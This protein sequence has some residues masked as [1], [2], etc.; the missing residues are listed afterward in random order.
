MSMDRVMRVALPALLLAL[1]ACGGGGG[2]GGSTASPGPQPQSYTDPTIYSSASTASIAQ[3]VETTAVTHHAI[4]VGGTTLAYTA[5]AGHLTALGTG[6]AAEASFFYVA[7]TL[8]GAAPATRPVTFFYNGGPG[9]ASA[10]LHLGSY[11]PRRLATGMPGTDAPTPFPLVD[12]AETLLDVSD[13]VFVDAIGSGWSEAVAPNANR[14]FWSVDADAAVF[15]DF[16][17]RYVAVNQRQASPKFLFGESYGTTRSAVLADLLESA[18]VDLKG[19]VLQSS[20][21][22]YNSNCA[23]VARIVSPCTGFVPSFA[24]IAT[25]YG[26]ANPLPAPAA[27]PDFIAQARTLAA[28]RFDPAVRASMASGAVPDAGLLASLASFTGVPAAMWQAHFNMPPDFYRYNAVT[29]KTLGRYDARVS[30]PGTAP[31]SGDDDPSSYLLTPSFAFRIGDYLSSE[32]GYTSPSTYVLLSNAIQVWNFSHDGRA[33]PDTIPDLASA[34][35]QNPKL[36]VLVFDGYDDL[37]TPFFTTEGDLARLPASNDVQVRS[38]V[39]GHM[40]YL[41]DQARPAAKADLA[42]FYR[43]ALGS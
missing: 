34:F 1:S 31:P 41:D 15:R 36:K 9:S 24:A 8:D 28:T 35:A 12:N 27:F 37:A 7:Y 11:G 26:I 33:L 6:G 16:V 13:L 20:V 5:T 17:M 18:G 19:V 3:P 21:L 38:Y 40:L 14:T 30:V 10:W 2:G 4:N 22:D 32:L 43:R 42:A 23:L 29:G 39:G 25:W